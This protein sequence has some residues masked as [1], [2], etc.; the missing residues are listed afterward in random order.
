MKHKSDNPQNGLER[1]PKLVPSGSVDRV[2]LI[3]GKNLT[4]FQSI[5]LLFIGI[6]FVIVGL[7]GGVEFGFHG[8]AVYLL[9]FVAA[10]TLWGIAMIVNGLRSIAGRLFRSKRT[11]P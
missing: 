2:L 10:I 1:L 9:L 3:G 6:C 7:F 8:Y 11:N 4:I 5:G